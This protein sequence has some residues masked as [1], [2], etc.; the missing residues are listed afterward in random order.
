MRPKTIQCIG[1]NEERTTF[2]YVLNKEICSSGRIEWK[3]TITPLNDSYSDFFEFIAEEIDEE[4]FKI[5]TV[6]HNNQ[7]IYIAKGIPEQMIF[8]LA[9]LSTK[10]IISSSNKSHSKKIEGEFRTPQATK[11]WERIKNIGHANYLEEKDIYSFQ[12]EKSI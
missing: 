2:K 5:K 8:E 3:F 7:E 6:S 4:T 10:N 11:V 1:R 12:R 9:S